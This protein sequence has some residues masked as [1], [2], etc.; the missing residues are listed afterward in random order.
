[1]VKSRAPTVEEDI[2]ET[3]RSLTETITRLSTHLTKQPDNLIAPLP[4]AI[5]DMSEVSRLLTETI[6]R[7]SIYL[8]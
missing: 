2:L 7:L 6:A 8:H 1:M 4:E 3:H 5:E